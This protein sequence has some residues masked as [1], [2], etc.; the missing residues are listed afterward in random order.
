VSGGRRHTDLQQGDKE[1]RWEEHSKLPSGAVAGVAG[2]NPAAGVKIRQVHGFTD[3][4]PVPVAFY[5]S[6][7]RATLTVTTPKATKPLR[8][9]ASSCHLMFYSHLG[10]IT[11]ECFHITIMSGSMAASSASTA[12][13]TS[14]S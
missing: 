6:S 1:G 5:D 14:S 8:R 7:W 2:R 13:S 3:G 4:V 11:N 9:G 10:T 12:A